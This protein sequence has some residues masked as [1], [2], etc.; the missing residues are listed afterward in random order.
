MRG[1]GH[2]VALFLKLHKGGGGYG[3][4]FGDYVVGL[5]ALNHTAQSLAVEHAEHMAAL[6]HLHCGRAA[7]A[8]AG[9][10]FH[11]HALKLD[12]HFLA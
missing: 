3:L 4:D 8:V 10:H 7:V 5:L 2:M 11:T 12:G 1:R 9:H 6:R